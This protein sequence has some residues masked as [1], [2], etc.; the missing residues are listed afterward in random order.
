MNAGL[1]MELNQLEE[2][3]ADGIGLFRTELQFLIS[4][5]LPRMEEQ[6]NF[7]RSVLDAAKGKKVIF[8]TLDIGGD[9][10]LPYMTAPKEENPALGWRA[11]RVALDRP[12][13][14]RLQLRALIH[15][16]ENNELSVMFPMIAE[17]DEL[18]QAKK[19][20]SKEISRM[21]KFNK[22]L[23][24]KISIGSML[25][26]P[27]LIWQFDILLPEVDFISVGSNDL[28]QFLFAADRGNSAIVDRYSILKPSALR[29]LKQA[30]DKCNDFRVPIHICGDISGKFSY[31]LALLG[32]GFRSFSLTPADIGPIK[33]IVRSLHL[34]DLEKFM[35]SQL[36]TDLLAIENNLLLYAE[37]NNI[38][39]ENILDA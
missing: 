36:K 10:I 39:L 32:L 23:P 3:G 37:Q 17:F 31:V 35:N 11:I 15:A 29:F 22:L 14:L 28:M 1:V 2:S 21:K 13:L 30:V 38:I 20:L 34:G 24:K 7:Y 16:S 4:E 27:S 9:K 5:T 25:E 33:K 12:G 18:M 26:I 8:R 19:L 6:K